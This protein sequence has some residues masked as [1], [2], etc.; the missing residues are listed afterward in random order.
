MIRKKGS[1][2]SSSSK[3][4]NKNQPSLSLTSSKSAQVTI[5]IISG[6]IIL[7]VFAGVLLV[8]KYTTKEE[9][10]SEA[11]PIISKVPQEFEPVQ[12]YTEN[13][14]AQTA[15]QGLILLG[16]QGGYINPSVL[17]SFSLTSPTDQAG[18][19]LEP[20]NVPYWHY[21]VEPNAAKTVTFA[22][23]K[24]ELRGS[25]EFS[26][27]KQLARYVNEHI[28]ECLGNYDL[29]GGLGFE[30]KVSDSREVEVN[31]KSGGVDIILSQDIIVKKGEADTKLSKF[32][33][34][35]PLDLN[36][37]YDVAD[38]ITTAE[39]DYNFLEKQGLEL[40]SVYS[41]I[42]PNKLPPT[43][44]VTYELF[45]PYSWN[46]RDIKRKYQEVLGSYV[47]LLRYLGSGNFYYTQTDDG[48][49]AQKVID[50]TVLPLD[51]AEDLDVS[52]DYLNWEPYFKTNS[53]GEGR[54]KPEHL[55][56]NYEFLAFGQQRYDTHYDVSYPVLV[57]LHDS[58]AFNGEGYNFVF[59]LESNIRNNAPAVGGQVKSV[60]P[61]PIVPL[62]CNSDHRD[63]EL[64]K[65]I[66][67]DSFTKEPLDLVKVGFTIP[68]QDECEIGI[69][70][71][72]GV[73]EEKYPAVQG[74]VINF[75]KT[76]YLTNLYPIDTYDTRDQPLI[77]GSA[78]AGAT[79][80]E[81]VIEMHQ[82]HTVN[83]TVKK[84]NF[85]KCLRPMECSY[86]LG[87]IGAIIPYT[88]I[89]CEEGVRQCFFNGGNTLLTGNPDFTIVG[90]RSLSQYHD[91]YFT[92]QNSDLENDEQVIV[93]LERMEG[94]GP[95]VIGNEHLVTAVI[96][97][98]ASSGIQLVPGRYKVNAVLTKNSNLL[99]PQD[100]RCFQYHILVVGTQSCITIDESNLASH[101]LG[102]LDWN[103]TATYLDITAADLYTS[104][105]LTFY[106]PAQ[107]IYNSP[108]AITSVQKQCGAL[109]CLPGLGCIGEV[110]RDQNIPIPGRVIE[111]ISGGTTV[112]RLSNEPQFRSRLEPQWN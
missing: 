85:E 36:H 51:G 49:L 112:S 98:P 50:N 79:A 69:T 48:L 7:F 46:E 90:N 29:F 4:K 56:V 109:T 13:C 22:S 40:V 28:D 64:I 107:G 33:V 14:L 11:R 93:T 6:I 62:V 43:S 99:V 82:L 47:P 77:L 75:V 18:I 66:I 9:L 2:C 86:T 94:L 78:V 31:I 57:R 53:D 110:C 1:G 23:L 106:I 73:V 17:G 12:I 37:Y 15:K 111:E 70:D 16:Q 87:N 3:W 67:V 89:D 30:F 68:N 5:F 76:G 63:S 41:G 65:T 59:A 27:D 72:F 60:Y 83:I 61:R 108:A 10:F 26:I 45:S 91:Y 71:D 92:N 81:R 35:I 97:G 39:I 34:G 38:K 105:Q 52:F 84:R 58:T 101:L 96:Q 25:A 103:S 32:Y 104:N 55:F 8:T 80:G 95:G 20:T 24:P 74:G 88:D 44:D 54:I 100:E 102:G 42:D 19:N 21:N